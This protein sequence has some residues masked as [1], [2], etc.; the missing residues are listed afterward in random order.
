MITCSYF[1]SLISQPS[2]F[3][4]SVTTMS[5]CISMPQPE[6]VIEWWHVHSVVLIALRT[7]PIFI[8]LFNRKSLQFLFNISEAQTRRTKSNNPLPT[9]PVQSLLEEFSLFEVK[10]PL[11]NRARTA[12]YAAQVTKASDLLALVTCPHSTQTR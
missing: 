11:I 9:Q 8:S 5:C 4:N 12:Q 3:S 1:T 2:C 10:F 7:P 6:L